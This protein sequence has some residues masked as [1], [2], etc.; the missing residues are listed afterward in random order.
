[1][2]IHIAGEI[3]G[4]KGVNFSIGNM[5]FASDGGCAQSC[6]PRAHVQCQ[7]WPPQFEAITECNAEDSHRE[8]RQS[9][10]SNDSHLLHTHHRA[11]AGLY[12]RTLIT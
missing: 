8:H 11:L 3:S 12:P 5:L 6:C 1:M 7:T 9:C 2:G 10:P 4:L